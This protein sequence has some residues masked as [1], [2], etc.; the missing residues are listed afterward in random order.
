MSEYQFQYGMVSW[1]LYLL[2]DKLVK[3]QYEVIKKILIEKIIVKC[4]IG[5]IETKVWSTK[6]KSK[7][8]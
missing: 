6:I 3:L 8:N 7:N 4:C 2:E 5:Q 1:S